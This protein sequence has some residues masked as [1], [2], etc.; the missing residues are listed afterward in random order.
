MVQNERFT[1]FTFINNFFIV[2]THHKINTQIWLMP[3]LVDG[4][5][6]ERKPPMWKT[7][8]KFTDLNLE[9]I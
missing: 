7:L 2:A 5:I 8:R 9:Q 6:L 4:L 1:A 3:Y